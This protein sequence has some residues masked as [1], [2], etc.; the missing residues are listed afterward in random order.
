MRSLS[1]ILR[2]RSGAFLG[3]CGVAMLLSTG[4]TARAGKLSWLDDVVREVIA[5]T[6]SGGKALARGGE[7]ARAEARGAGRLFLRHDAEEGLEQLVKRSDDLARAGRKIEQPSEALLQ[8]RF[9]RL[10]GHD[11][12]AVR[13]FEALRPAEKRLVVEMG[14]AAQRLARRHPQEAEA[15]ARQLGPEGLTAVRVFG[16][17]V[18]EVIAKEG[19][20]S[21]NVLRKTGRGGWEFFTGQV[22]PHKKKLLAAGVLAAFLADPDKFVD[23]A[24]QATEYAAREFA[25]AGIGLAAAVGSGA[26]QGLESSLGQALAARGLDHPAFRTVG[27]ALASLVAIGALL[28]L[29]GL[30]LRIMVRPFTAGLGIVHR[31]SKSLAGARSSH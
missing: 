18:A 19:T 27:M 11:A 1:S 10:L 3:A 28:V 17:D 23:Y 4:G 26:A 12:D 8:G 24:G 22:L 13:S 5:E 31:L 15:M 21:L 14:E 20:E 29:V 25:R 9:T 6:K 2:R 7:A 30:P 16:D